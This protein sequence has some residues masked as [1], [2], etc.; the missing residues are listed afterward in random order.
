MVGAELFYGIDIL[1]G[2]LVT[3]G[4]KQGSSLRSE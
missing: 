1:M 4:E 2:V 3:S